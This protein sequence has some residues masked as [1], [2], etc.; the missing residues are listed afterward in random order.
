MRA[1]P[2]RLSAPGSLSARSG[3]PMGGLVTGIGLAVTGA[4]AFGYSVAWTTE[5]KDLHN[6]RMKDQDDLAELG[7]RTN[8]ATVG[9]RIFTAAGATCIGASVVNLQF[10]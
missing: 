7:N 4:I 3:P 10:R 6:P 2:T 5:F 1:A 9:A 8:I